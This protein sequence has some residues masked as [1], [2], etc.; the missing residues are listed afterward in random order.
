[1]L[2]DFS[3]EGTHP[4]MGSARARCRHRRRAILAV[5]ALKKEVEV[6][7]HEVERAQTVYRELKR[8]IPE[9]RVELNYDNALELMVATV[10]AAQS[11]DVKVNE[12]TAVLFKKY[13]CAADYVAV[14]TEELEEDIR[15]TGFYRQKAKNIR[16]AM[17]MLIVD[18]D[19]QVPGQ[20][21][22]LTRLPGIGRKSANVIL[23]NVYGVPGI[24]VDTHVGRVSRRL[25]LTAEKDPVKVEMALAQLLPAEEWTAFGQRV[26]LHGRYVC[27]ARKPLCDECVLM[28]HCDYFASQIEGT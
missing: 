26:V 12:V 14:A 13:Q 7:E 9:A 28:P 18:H 21:D 6:E 25:G 15:P 8:T 19:G 22:A 5:P 24:V 2:G 4:P 16:A 23:G 11:T 27:K 10:L 20:M 17:A 3:L 1:M